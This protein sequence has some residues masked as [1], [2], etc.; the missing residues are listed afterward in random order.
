MGT[1][2]FACRT[3][4]K[5]FEASAEELAE[6]MADPGTH[7]WISLDQ[8]G[9]QHKRILSDVLHLHPLLIEDALDTA[10]TPKA[11]VHSDYT[12]LILHG[13]RDR[14]HEAQASGRDDETQRGDER[15]ERVETVDVDFFL[16]NEYIVTHHRLPM[17]SLDAVRAMVVGEGSPLADGPARLAHELIDRMV[18]AYLPMM[19][20]IDR[21]VVRVERAAI[22]DPDPKLLESIFSLKHTLQSIRRVGLHQREVLGD[23]AAGRYPRVPEP[24]RPF[25][26]DVQDHFVRVMDLNESYRDLVASSL[27]AYLSMQSHRLNE[28]M[29]IL[30]V[31][32]TIMLPLTFIT[33]L[34]GMNFD[35]MPLI[36]WRYGYE[37]AWAVM[38]GTAAVFW[39]YGKRKRWL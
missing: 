32:S 13:L 16:G 6:L 39:W 2:I 24:I 8:Q 30:T 34:Y 36:H 35:E 26:R 15:E 21:D 28:V 29:K 1:R 17:P 4:G 12:Y 18:D 9:P 22:E 11:E 20:R 7:V 37:A 19:E 38:I 10:P 5:G 3:G 33:G 31:I 14:Q 25:F 27:D 23:L